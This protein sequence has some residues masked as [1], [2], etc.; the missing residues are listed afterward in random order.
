MSLKKCKIK[1][2][3]KQLGFLPKERKIDIYYKK[4]VNFNYVIEIDFN[5]EKIKYGNLI[6]T[7]D[8]T[9]CNFEKDENLVVLECVNRLLE[10]GYH[11]PKIILEY[12]WN[13]GK[14]EKGKLDILV[15]DD[16]NKAYLMIECKTWDKEFEKEK[17]YM[18]NNGGQ[19]FS[20]FQQDT[21]ANFLCLYSSKLIDDKV[22]YKNLIVKVNE[23]WRMLSNVKEIHD[24][25]N[26]NFYDNGIF[27]FDAT[28]Y[29]IQT[30]KLTLNKLKN[31]T[32]EDSNK[33]FNQFAE[34]LRH[35][36]ISDKPN[37]FNKILNM[38]I[39][40][41]IDEDRDA[42]EELKFQIFEEDTDK[43]LQ[44]RL[45]NLY[46]LGMEKFLHI[47]VSDYDN[48]EIESLLV[49][50]KENTKI[51]EIY[52]DLRLK[53]NPEFAFKEVYDDRS[54]NENGIVVREI[55]ELLQPYKFRY[56]H[57]HQFLGNFFEL[58]LNTS[59]KQEAGQFFTPVPIAKFIVRCLPISELIHKKMKN[60]EK[61]FLPYIID[62]AVGS[63][64]FLTEYMDEVQ[65]LLMDTNNVLN[66][67]KVGTSIKR[68]LSSYINDPFSW[69]KEY[70]YGIDA[71]YRLIKTAKVAAFLNGDGEANLIR[72]NGL[73]NFK[74]SSD[75]I[76]LL[77]SDSNEKDNQNFDIL[78][79]N[80]PY[81]VSSFKSTLKYGDKTF[82]LFKYLTDN[83]SEIECLFIERTK[84]LLKDGGI[85]GIILPSSI[86]N[87]SG[88]Y[89]RSREIIFNY[90]N[91][92]GIVELGSNTFMATG[93]NTI[94]LFLERKN[95]Y[96]NT[97]IKK[98]IDNFF[99][100]FNDIVIN[101]IEK[102]ISKY[103]SYVWENISFDDYISIFKSNPSK[104][105]IAHEIYQEY[106]RKYSK[107]MQ[108]K[109]SYE[110]EL[111]KIIVE[112]EKQKLYYF[113]IS[114]CQKIVLIKSGKKDK[115]KKFLGYEFS[116]RRGSE[117]IHPFKREKNI[118]ECTMLFDE[119]S[120][121]NPKKAS[122][123]MYNAFKGIFNLDIE[124]E[125]E[126][127]VSYQNL[128][129]MLVFNRSDFENNISTSIKK[130]MKY[131][132]IWR[133]KNFVP[134]SKIS[135]IKKG[136]SIT[137]EK[138][139]DGNIPVIAG[140]KE[141][142]Y[143]HDK[144]N[145]NGNVITISASGAYSG[146]VN[147][148]DYP[149]FASDCNTVIS[150]DENIISTKLIYYFLKH[151]QKEIYR[152]Q[153][154]QA[155][156]HVYG[157]DIA[158]I[159]IPLPTLENQQYIIE[160]IES[161]ENK[162]ET[163]QKQIT[164]IKKQ[165]SLDNISKDKLIKLKEAVTI[166]GG[167][168][169]RPIKKFLTDSNSG[170]NWIKIGDVDVESK[171]ITK[172][173][174]KIT[175]EGASKSRYVKIGDFILSNSMS[176]GRPYIL[177][178]DGCIHDGWLLLTNFQKNIINKEFLYYLLS[179]EYIQEEFNSAASGGTS[180]NNLNIE[181]VSN[182]KIPIL[183]LSEQEKIV[184]NFLILEEKIVKAKKE[185]FKFIEE[186]ERIFDNY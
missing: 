55:V 122:F 169:P 131:E 28:P 60:N 47:K 54:F 132:H 183:T 26:K 89:S 116:S 41:I 134:L 110:S 162:I 93:T 100:N 29:N 152:M 113:I 90:F 50:S 115:E 2:I 98:S 37:A 35:N 32:N 77:K 21:S 117:G 57:K 76:G 123:Y 149:I 48:N 86:L 52:E 80:P 18:E 180:V 145:R 62:Y 107:K 102:P 139:R 97:Y 5:K 159:K 17:T 129:D 161:L 71:D 30:K 184:E 148:F 125:L 112:I 91:I 167:A 14:K 39:C 72:G 95:N 44:L 84:Q 23:K 82:D 81:S 181:K 154:G 103:V 10:K 175:L 168:S 33:I 108:N 165:I 25:W 179:S 178:I 156:P 133:N 147:Y 75:F 6:K 140:G 146:F 120:F 160:R 9:T 174:E 130:K 45:N 66:D 38:F 13:L 43:T 155:Q 177:E 1:D 186:K 124:K 144:P 92:L 135:I 104:N 126:N 59:I 182:I 101:G 64:H 11:P 171:Y 8:A 20:Y 106:R 94:V 79:A 15:L 166:T 68:S 42:N 7:G 136:T 96:V 114:Y 70:V 63:G 53:K 143:F 22:E 88:I 121:E 4:Y 40:K 83:S 12:K 27:E 170:V 73:D 56:N 173:K 105:I 19:L 150:K 128:M 3:V 142:A 78:I 85:A 74:N 46:K 176:Y 99:I 172:T 24:H 138:T 34:I 51:K 61:Y 153:E 157:K 109:K 58:L 127:N 111:L 185:K 65:N 87:N 163:I 141:L 31:L 158:Q 151:M 137:K 67:F 16:K 36:V 118:A 49:D 164:E 119:E 69:A